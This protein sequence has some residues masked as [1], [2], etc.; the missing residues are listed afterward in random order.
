MAKKRKLQ[1][2]ETR[3]PSGK[4]KTKFAMGVAGSSV[5]AVTRMTPFVAVTVNRTTKTQR[6][7]EK[8]G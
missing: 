5:A 7:L 8:D 1:R 4:S 2:Q 6:K 3:L